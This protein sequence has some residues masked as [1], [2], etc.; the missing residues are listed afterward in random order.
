MLSLHKQYMVNEKGEKS[1]VVL[2]FAEWEKILH[3]L[4]E[5]DD[6][7]AYDKAKAQKSDPVDWTDVKNAII[8]K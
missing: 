7:C 1:A 8:G 4:E 5:Y 3:L 2:P 6:I